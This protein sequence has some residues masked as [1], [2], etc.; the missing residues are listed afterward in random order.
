MSNQQEAYAPKAVV[1]SSP[2]I[3]ESLKF[4]EAAKLLNSSEHARTA[5]VYVDQAHQLGLTATL[6]NAIG[7]WADGAENT[8][9]SEI[10]N[11]KS[12][13]DTEKLAAMHGL[14]SNQKAVIPFFEESA[15][16]DTLSKI[17]IRRENGNETE[18]RKSLD[19]E[20]LQYRT[21]LPRRDYTH[22]VIFDKGSELENNVSKFADIY[23]ARLERYKGHGEFLG[24]DTRIEGKAAYRRVL[25]KS[26]VTLM[27]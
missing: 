14:V 6:F 2:N 25:K 5:K 19:G 10:V 22:V 15:G 26:P 18:I 3:K 27:I 24:G 9:Y 7:D 12:Y 23:G 21:I 8:I 1:F 20:G 16:H 13:E 4:E 17:T 11:A